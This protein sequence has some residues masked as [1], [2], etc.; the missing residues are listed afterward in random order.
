MA[1]HAEPANTVTNNIHVSSD[2]Y[3]I[4]EGDYVTTTSKP[5]RKGG[6][7]W[8]LYKPDM[9]PRESFDTYGFVIN[10][11]FPLEIE[12]DENDPVFKDRK[13]ILDKFTEGFVVSGDPKKTKN[14]IH[15]DHF[16]N[17]LRLGSAEAH[18][19]RSP[20]NVEKAYKFLDNQI[21]KKLGKY[22]GTRDEV[23][24]QLKASNT[25]TKTLVLTQIAEEI[26][27]LQRIQ[28]AVRE[29]LTSN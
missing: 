27:L 20:K 11:Y 2:E 25:K 1:N 10:T 15:K 23:R 24:K 4:P 17:L 5:I 28:T 21:S 8:N 12:L 9:D 26:E 18:P 29:L 13:R 16:K 3:G 14:F 6:E 7:I 22:I 19:S